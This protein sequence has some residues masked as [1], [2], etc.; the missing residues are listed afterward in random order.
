LSW[1]YARKGECKLLGSRRR[2]V[3]HADKERRRKVITVAIK[4]A[5]ILF[6]SYVAGGGIYNYTE[7][8]PRRIIVPWTG[9]PSSIHY[10]FKEQTRGE[11]QIAMLCNLTTV[12]GLI[13]AYESTRVGDDRLKANLILLTGIALALL[14][15]YGSRYLFFLK[16]NV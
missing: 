15:F 14:G 9:R 3:S 10:D 2:T 16:Q 5:L 1:H 7:K 8:P 13:L 4:L 11:G 12:V 6:S